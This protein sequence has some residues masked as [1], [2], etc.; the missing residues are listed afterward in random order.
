MIIVSVICLGVALYLYKKKERSEGPGMRTGNG[1]GT[2]LY[3]KSGYD[4]KDG[5]YISTKWFMI[6]LIPILPLGS[7]RVIKERSADALLPGGITW[8]SKKTLYKMQKVSLH[9]RQIL[10]TYIITAL[11]LTALFYA[12][13]YLFRN[14]NI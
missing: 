9:W 3:G 1:S 5:S 11:I 14:P 6:M 7:Y 4:P 12:I 2:G 13:G 10:I 8:Y